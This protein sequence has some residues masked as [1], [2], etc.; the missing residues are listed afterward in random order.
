MRQQ[1]SQGRRI[2]NADLQLVSNSWRRSSCSNANWTGTRQQDRRTSESEQLYFVLRVCMTAIL[3]S[4][5]VPNTAVCASVSLYTS[6]R[7]LLCGTCP[8]SIITMA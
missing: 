5:L 2:V 3:P 4:T 8:A 6:V 7:P 1:R